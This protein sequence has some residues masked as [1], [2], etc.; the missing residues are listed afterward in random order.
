MNLLFIIK[1]PCPTSFKYIEGIRFLSKDKIKIKVLSETNFSKS[2]WMRLGYN[3]K[4]DKTIY[5]KN[6]STLS[7][8]IKGLFLFSIMWKKELKRIETEK[9]DIIQTITPDYLPVIANKYLKRPIFHHMREIETIFPI[10][11]INEGI[12]KIYSPAKKIMLNLIEKKA[13][14]AAD[15]LSFDSAAS[16]NIIKNKYN[17]E[18]KMLILRNAP[19][20]NWVPKKYKPKLSQET[21]ETTLVFH[22]HLNEGPL[23]F[24]YEICRRNIQLHLYPIIKS[25]KLISKIEELKR[26]PSFHLHDSIVGYKDLIYELSQYDYGLIPP[27]EDY[28]K[29]EFFN[30][31]LPCKV[32]DYI[33]AGLKV[34]SGNFK[35]IKEYIEFNKLGYTIKN[36]DELL[37]ILKSKSN[38][39]IKPQFID[40]DLKEL[41]ILYEQYI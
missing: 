18:K 29:L 1:E 3:V 25:K 12:K 9:I 10:H 22:G 40:D 28:E 7:K 31:Y 14:K 24:F 26:F 13:I 21:G 4:I 36:I 6:I 33:A 5:D 37:C 11:L 34:I 39:N 15:V 2:I 16:L 35:Q 38:L 17:C 41:I 19:L 30:A 23:N 8:V 20:S 27:S 32:F